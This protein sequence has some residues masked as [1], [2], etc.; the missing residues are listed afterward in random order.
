MA[1][2]QQQVKI[3]QIWI[4]MWL[5]AFSFKI[6]RVHGTHEVS[7]CVLAP[8]IN[9]EC[10]L[11]G[12]S[13]VRPAISLGVEKVKE[14]QILPGADLKVVYKNSKCSEIDATIEAFE[15]KDQKAHIFFGPVRDLA[16]N[17]VAQYAS[18]WNIPLITPGALSAFYFEDKFDKHT[19]T[20]IGTSFGDL[21]RMVIQILSFN[22][23][24]K[25][26]VI[27]ELG[28]TEYTSLFP[29]YY[30]FAGESFNTVMIGSKY[31]VDIT[32]Y[33]NSFQSLDDLLAKRIGGLYSAP[34]HPSQ[35]M[36]S[37]KKISP[38]VEIGI[39][40]VRREQL[41]PQ[42]DFT[43]HLVDTNFSSRV[44]PIRAM[45]LMERDQVHVFLGPVYDYS[46]APVA[47][48]APHWAVPVISPGGFAH[49][50]K[51]NR[52]EEYTTLTRIGPNFESTADFIGK[53]IQAH[54]WS[55][56]LLIYQ[57]DGQRFVFPRF[58]F[59]AASAYIYHFQRNKNK[60]IAKQDF[61]IYIPNKESFESLL[62][63]RVGEKY[64][65]K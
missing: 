19:L 30:S 23:W 63:N 44:A 33:T 8:D 24:D 29:E 4:Y 17:S 48:Y 46:L 10:S 49:D 34:Q 2:H 20:R 64:S 65:G 26:K 21:I 54:K 28:R 18:R 59:L 58:C 53:I 32:S 56:A 62:R 3:F 27:Y 9:H 37:L 51:S 42:V 16:V 38:G 61:H 57:G 47:R 55:R 7:I 50:F 22:K 31:D 12:L 6:L 25:F 40:Y 36:F 39:D 5:L 45:Q 41:L 43:V 14:M 60:H 1:S 13:K 52:L 15:M 11:F 35:R